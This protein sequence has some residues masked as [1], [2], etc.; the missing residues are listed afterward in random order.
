MPKG[1]Q[2]VLL[3]IS[4]LRNNGA[5]SLQQRAITMRGRKKVVPEAFGC[6][7]G[8]TWF[9]KTNEWCVAVVDVEDSWLLRDYKWTV[10]AKY[11]N[12]PFY[13]R[14]NRYRRETGKSCYLHQ[15]VTGHVYE[16]L[17]HINHNSHDC[18]K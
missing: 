7:C 14:S 16:R 18:R 3:W 17:D 9:A 8:K 6:E 4:R 11:L 12:W 10:E 1:V 2:W 13:A 15:A 5:W